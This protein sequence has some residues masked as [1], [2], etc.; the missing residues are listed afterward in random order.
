M[1][2]HI[3]VMIINSGFV[4]SGG[5]YIE[6]HW[7]RKAQTAAHIFT[8]ADWTRLAGWTDFGADRAVCRLCRALV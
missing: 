8:G 1:N 7:N 4:R 6:I 5:M 2:S 3:F